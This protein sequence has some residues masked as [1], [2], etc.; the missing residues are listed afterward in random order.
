MEK[1]FGIFV[2]KKLYIVKFLDFI[3][4]LDLDRLIKIQDWIGMVKYDS[5]L[6]S[7]YACNC[8]TM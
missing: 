6:I 2:V 7:G 3:G 1:N 5:P 8:A 4:W